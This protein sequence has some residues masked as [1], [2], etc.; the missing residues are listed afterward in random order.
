MRRYLV[1]SLYERPTES[2]AEQASCLWPAD[3]LFFEKS[4]HR[5]PASRMEVGLTGF[6][7]HSLVPVKGRS[8]ER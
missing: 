6:L 2:N 1:K 5:L 4:G 3:C 8:A 7:C